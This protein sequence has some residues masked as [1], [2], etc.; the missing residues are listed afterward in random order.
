MTFAI[1]CT[2]FVKKLFHLKCLWQLRKNILMQKFSF[3]FN[4]TYKILRFWDLME[5]CAPGLTSLN[6]S[7][8]YGRHTCTPIF[9]QTSLVKVCTRPKLK[10]LDNQPKSSANLNNPN[11]SLATWFSHAV[12]S[13]NHTIIAVSNVVSIVSQTC[14]LHR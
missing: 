7:P 4:V 12:S 13:D 1:K 5:S 8:L 14:K 2:L 9:K 10:I 11:C 6:F 3:I